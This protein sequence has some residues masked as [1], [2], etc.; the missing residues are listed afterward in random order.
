MYLV[1][2]FPPSN[3]QRVLSEIQR[4][5]FQEL[6]GAIALAIPPLV[7]LGFFAEK[8]DPPAVTAPIQECQLRSQ[9]YIVSGNHVYLDIAP[10]DEIARIRD[11]LV[12]GATTPLFP[13][14]PGVPIGIGL[15]KPETVLGWQTPGIGWKT[16]RLLCLGLEFEEN[17]E[18]W[19]NLVYRECW[20]VKLR[21]K[22]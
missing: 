20:G 8:P 3:I 6:S 10:A 2:L 17:A 14:L 19:E 4:R 16:C 22:I 11:P 12:G 18:W 21:R 1:A 7:P 13:V 9:D 15:R 5:V